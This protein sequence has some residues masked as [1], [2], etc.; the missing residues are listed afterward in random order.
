M[1]GMNE[2]RKGL[3][4]AAFA[5]VI[6]GLFPLYWHLLKSVPADQITAHRVVWSAVLLVAL[7]CARQG[8]GWIR[9]IAATPRALACW[10]W[11]EP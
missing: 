8:L 4:A 2:Q 9:A 6:W 3:L 1:S 7:L 5:F 10:P 11:P